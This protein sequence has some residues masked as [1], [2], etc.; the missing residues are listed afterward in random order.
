[1]PRFAVNPSIL[2]A[3]LA[4]VTL[5]ARPAAGAI[6]Y[7]GPNETHKTLRQAFSAMKGG[8]TLVIRDGTYTG[9][10]NCIGSVGADR[11]W[12]Q[13][14]SQ[15]PPS[16][17]PGAYTVIR[18]E[19]EGMVTFET[20]GVHLVFTVTYAAGTPA[21]SYVEFRGLKW[22]D[23][24]GT[25]GFG[26]GVQI[27]VNAHHVKWT[28]CGVLRNNRTT[29]GS[30][31]NVRMG[32][33]Y[34]FEECYAWGTMR[35]G[36]LISDNGFDGQASDLGAKKVVVRRCVVR[37][38]DATGGSTTNQ[39]VGAFMAYCA[40]EVEFQNNIVID[41]DN[42]YFDNWSYQQAL[43]MHRRDYNHYGHATDVRWRGNIV[44]NYLGWKQSNNGTTGP[45]PPAMSLL[46]EVASTPLVVE[47]NVLWDVMT[48]LSLQ[49]GDPFP[50][51][52]AVTLRGLTLKTADDSGGGA[53]FTP[54]PTRPA[55]ILPRF[56]RDPTVSITGRTRRES[57]T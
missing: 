56:R 34:L 53:G 19:H 57:G 4:L 30:A 48:G 27:R 6:V 13:D 26:G 35:Y 33:Y 42:S 49:N 24:E 47:N 21:F 10:D 23:R 20:D 2:A 25:D 15:I 51:V 12:G 46:N 45:Y 17:S 50:D 38:D 16:G 37:H 43:T 29:E 44:L 14:G 31:F 39:T 8:D 9:P 52:G 11:G 55:R 22:M 18:A 32:A 3:I 28:R 7:M 54:F 40:R 36:F 41:V 1:M 5:G